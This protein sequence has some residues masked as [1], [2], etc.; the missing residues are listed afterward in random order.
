MLLSLIKNIFRKN[1]GLERNVTR[2]KYDIS[3]LSVD[4][5]NQWFVDPNN[6]AV[7]DNIG[8]FGRTDKLS[9]SHID[10][11]LEKKYGLTK[12]DIKNIDYSDIGHFY[13]CI[14]KN[15]LNKYTS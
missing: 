2:P 7:Y 8:I 5:F 4:E 12:E 10:D 1:K 14:R 13:T 6:N 11:F 15:W 9:K 3:M